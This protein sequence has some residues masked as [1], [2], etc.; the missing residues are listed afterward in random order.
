MTIVSFR[1]KL[2]TVCGITQQQGREALTDQ[3]YT[4]LVHLKRLA[5][6]DIRYLVREVNR[7]PPVTVGQQ[8]IKP[9]VPFS[10]IKTLRAA[11]AWVIKRERLGTTIADINDDDFTQEE[12]SRMLTR[13]DYED[14]FKVNQ[15]EPPELPTKF[16]GFGD[17]WR[18]FGEG[19]VGHLEV[20]RGVMNIPLV[21]V[22][23]ETEVP[24]DEQRA[25]DY[26]TTD[27]KLVALVTLSGDEYKQ[28]SA[29]VWDLLRPLVYGTSA[30][31]YVKRYD[32]RKDGRK[33]FRTLLARG[34]GEVALD[35]RRVKADEIIATAKYTGEG[36]R[37]TVS[38]LINLLQNAF[39]ER[40][41]CGESLSEKRKVE[42]LAKAL[43]H[44]RLRHIRT[45][46][47][48]NPEY[49]NDF[50]RAYTFVETME[51]YDSAGLFSKKGGHSSRN[52]SEVKAGK[53]GDIPYMS[54]KEWWDLDPAERLRIQQA[55]EKAR[56]GKGKN[57]SKKKKSNKG[58]KG[59]GD[60][61][62]EMKR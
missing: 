38:S 28:D 43:Q 12:L 58:S 47:I 49:R 2:N 5:D 3:G 39:S 29:R 33:A 34:D 46:L 10:A 27:A 35:A 37:F 31:S 36:R 8:Q 21:Y 16:V 51:Q 62:K 44:D 14:K 4:E 17:K 48:S 55:R 53:D 25:A 11:R 40:E 19:F 56:G 32:R 26:H 59:S 52:V 60:P 61:F 57:G 54:N 41:I 13:L 22:V 30:W 6:A 20:A 24:T 42:I 15:P 50:Q 9:T 45:T 7:L 1:E 23:R 18:A